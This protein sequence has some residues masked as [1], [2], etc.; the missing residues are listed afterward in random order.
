MNILEKIQNY[1]REVYWL[2][3]MTLLKIDPPKNLEQKDI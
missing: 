1:F 3:L 2:G